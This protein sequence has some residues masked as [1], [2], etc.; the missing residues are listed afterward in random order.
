MPSHIREAG[1]FAHYTALEIAPKY[2]CSAFSAVVYLLCY[3]SLVHAISNYGN[4]SFYPLCTALEIASNYACS[5]FSAVIYLLCYR[6]LV[7]AISNYRNRSFYRN[8][9][10]FMHESLACR[11]RI[12]GV[13][14]AVKAP[15][16]FYPGLR[17]R[18][19]FYISGSGSDA[20]FRLKN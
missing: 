3:R 12:R 2:T 4:S 15:I 1:R 19:L 17:I 9:V 7:H 18:I 8:S 10:E 20:F 16:L 13:S 5:T 11:T 6:S 14:G